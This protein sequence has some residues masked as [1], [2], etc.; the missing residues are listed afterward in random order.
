MVVVRLGCERLGGEN[1]KDN[2]IL[3]IIIDTNPAG[4]TFLVWLEFGV[5]NKSRLFFANNLYGGYFVFGFVA[6]RGI[7]GRNK[8]EIN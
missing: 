3:A 5:G 1:K 6:D 8:L 7:S 4:K 2:P